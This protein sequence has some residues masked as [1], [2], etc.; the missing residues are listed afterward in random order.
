MSKAQPEVTMR[1][2]YTYGKPILFY[3][4]NLQGL[5]NKTETSGFRLQ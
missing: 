4:T 3:L 2:K 5:D 1:N